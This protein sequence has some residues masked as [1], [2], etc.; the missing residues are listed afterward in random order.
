MSTLPQLAAESSGGQDG[1]DCGPKPLR[2][3][4]IAKVARAQSGQVTHGAG[5]VAESGGSS[6][7]IP[8]SH[9]KHRL[10]RS[11]KHTDPAAPPFKG[12]QLL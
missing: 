3:A 8:D 6:A 11:G 9:D 5:G 1:V 10:Q 4:N 7:L 12:A 2:D